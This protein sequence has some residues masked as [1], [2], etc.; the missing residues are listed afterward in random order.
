MKYIDLTKVL[1][2]KNEKV[3]L[4]LDDTHVYTV[5]NSRKTMEVVMATMKDIK[6]EDDLSKGLDAID[7]LI[8]KVLGKEAAEVT[9][10]YTIAAKNVLLEAISGAFVGDDEE[11]PKN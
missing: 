8:E 1:Q 7:E 6:K 5:N 10:D 11:K 3:T 4:R 9:K 2:E